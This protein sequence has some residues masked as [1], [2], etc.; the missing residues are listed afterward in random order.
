MITAALLTILKTWKKSKCPSTHEWIKKLQYIY[1]MGCYSA[2]KK[3]EM[4]P[5]AA[6]RMQREMI[7]LKK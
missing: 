5:S 4:T 7:M 3:K 6:T 2:I 1:A